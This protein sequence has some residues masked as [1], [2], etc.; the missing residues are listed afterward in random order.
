MQEI[1]TVFVKTFYVPVI[2]KILTIP[3]T[4]KHCICGVKEVIKRTKG[5]TW[6]A[7]LSPLVPRRGWWQLPPG[8]A[9]SQSVSSGI[10][11]G[12]FS[13]SPGQFEAGTAFKMHN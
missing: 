13:S 3:N 10:P 2:K 8:V 7:L 6:R 9:A 12:G 5:F 1:V 11:A 4:I